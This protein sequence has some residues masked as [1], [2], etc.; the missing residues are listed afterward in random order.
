MGSAGRLPLHNVISHLLNYP[1]TGFLCNFR[2]KPASFWALVEVLAAKGGDEYWCQ[3]TGQ[4]N[5]GASGYPIHE[6]VAVALYVLG[7]ATMPLERV[8]SAL[9][10]GKGS[11]F[12]YLWR[13]I[14]LL[15]S[16]A[17]EYIQWPSIEV[18]NQQKGKID[19]EVFI[20]CAGYLDGSEIP[21]CNAP[22][23]NREDYFS[24]KKIYGFNLQAICDQ[25]SQ[26]IFAATGFTAS[27][28]DSTAFKATQFY[29]NRQQH[30]KDDEYI[31]ADKA[32]QLD[33]YIIPPFKAPAANSPTCKA[34]N[35]AHSHQHIRI[36]HAFGVLKAR[37][38][39]LNCL[40]IR[41]RP[42]CVKNDHLRASSWIYACM[43]LH[44]YLASRG[45]SEEWLGLPDIITEDDDSIQPPSQPNTSTDDCDLMGEGRIK[46]DLLMLRIQQQNKPY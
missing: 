17:S 7:S 31:L 30:M 11:I 6:Q 44:N 5:G 29:Q 43:V 35:K 14:Q 42:N 13:T 36:E 34:F 27:A 10:I 32:Y 39:S 16:M 26:F 2:M 24:R 41:I 4:G 38:A 19:D 1:E 23:Q 21:L 25:D 33:K 46:R 45:D 18:R 9:N 37:W 12:N 15:D 22:T 40:P 20:N 3:N 8:R 28:H